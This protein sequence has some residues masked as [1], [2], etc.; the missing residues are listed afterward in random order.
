[1][2]VSID[3]YRCYY[4]CTR[5]LHVANVLGDASQAHDPCEP[6]SHHYPASMVRLDDLE[7]ELKSGK[8]CQITQALADYRICFAHGQ[9]DAE[10]SF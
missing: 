8:K 3:P 5:G 2:N 7:A 4:R 1:M 10:G 6:G 9:K